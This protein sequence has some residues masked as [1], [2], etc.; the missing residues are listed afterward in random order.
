M[1]DKVALRTAEEQIKSLEQQTKW[2]IGHL[3]ASD[4]A[5]A[6]DAWSAQRNGKVAK[7]LVDEL[8]VVL[9]TLD[10]AR[11]A[12]IRI[13]LGEGLIEIDNLFTHD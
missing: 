10:Q 8:K 11:A 2:L 1:I 6:P 3:L 7:P 12:I 13:A 4:P 9:I 5:G